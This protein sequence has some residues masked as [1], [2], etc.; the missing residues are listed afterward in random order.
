MQ[1][2]LQA[3]SAHFVSQSLKR[4]LQFHRVYREQSSPESL[5]VLDV[6]EVPAGVE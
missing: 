5:L 3:A 2:K 6:Q 1:M 4:S